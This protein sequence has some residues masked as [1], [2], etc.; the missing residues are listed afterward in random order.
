MKNN[1]LLRLFLGLTFLSAGIYRIF[2]WQQAVIEFSRFGLGSAYYLIV[3]MIILEIVGGLMLIFDVK[4][5]EILLIFIIFI[6]ISLI[7]ALLVN[8]NN[9]LSGL[10]ELFTFDLTPTD[11]F[12]HFTY[13]I[14]LVYL[15]RE[16]DK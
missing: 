13:L 12:L 4:T 9:I 11:L 6:I 14:I 1:F 10:G 5:K 2:N 3:L 8:G 16:R 15:F 7:S